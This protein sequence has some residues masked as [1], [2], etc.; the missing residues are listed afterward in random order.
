MLVLWQAFPKQHPGKSI[1]NLYLGPL[2]ITLAAD[3]RYATSSKVDVAFI[4]ISAGLGPWR[5]IT[6]VSGAY[7]AAFLTA[8]L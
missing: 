5:F 3:Y 8:Y 4:D 7:R 2:Q 1:Q 6:L